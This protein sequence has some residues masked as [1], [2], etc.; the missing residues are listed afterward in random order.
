MSVL[1]S[2]PGDAH[3]APQPGPGP[4]R[5]AVLG[6]GRMGSRMAARLVAAGGDVTVWNRTTATAEAFA[7][8]HG[9]RAAATPSDA[10]AEADVVLTVVTDGPA[11]LAV[12]GGGRT[13][14]PADG[15]LD[16]GR[17]GT[18]VVDC[19]TVGAPAAREAAAR[20]AARGIDLLDAPVSGSTAV[21]EQGALTVMAGGSAEALGRARPVLDVLA[22]T[23]LH[24]GPSG[25]GAAVKVALNGLLHTFSTALAEALVTAE[26]EGVARG[27]FLDAVDAGV[28]GN[29]FAAYK[30]AAL[31]DPPS[32]PVA[33]DLV[34][35]TKDLRLAQASAERAGLPAGPVERVLRLHER[36]V[37]DG[38]GA[39]DIAA[40]TTWLAT[41]GAAPAAGAQSATSPPTTPTQT[42]T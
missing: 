4:G 12:L 28:L 16:G 1:P 7:A 19:S 34:T 14:D 42:R 11:L 18:V 22:A 31:L 41:A 29:R 36:A 38:H 30:R 10:A 21:A 26:A 23:V 5:V 6:L 9:C 39:D 32:Q 17:P 37:R 20:C 27:A 3:P 25:T 24:V 33:F 13:G 8:E 40:M 2:L 35:A 15:V